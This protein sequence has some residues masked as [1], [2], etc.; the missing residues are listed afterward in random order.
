MLLSGNAISPETA[1]NAAKRYVQPIE[2]EDWKDES[3]RIDKQQ[4]SKTSEEVNEQI[5]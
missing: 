3:K 2:N 4:L 1:F 5:S